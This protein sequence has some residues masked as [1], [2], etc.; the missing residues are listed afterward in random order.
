MKVIVYLAEFWSSK[1]W[2]QDAE[3]TWNFN[4]DKQETW[5]SKTIVVDNR[6]WVVITMFAP[7]TCWDGLM[8][9]KIWWTGERSMAMLIDQLHSCTYEFH[10][11][12][13]EMWEWSG[14]LIRQQCC[15]SRVKPEQM[16]EE[17]KGY[18]ASEV[19]E[20]IRVFWV[21]TQVQVCGTRSWVTMLHGDEWWSH[22]FDEI[23]RSVQADIICRKDEFNHLNAMNLD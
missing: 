21:V 15:E 4:G 19:G 1:R 22:L 23:Y 5:M 10:C 8:Q 11:N 12:W 6:S 16:M 13:S 3:E 2:H 20:N 9:S 7:K 14:K 18:K 17:L